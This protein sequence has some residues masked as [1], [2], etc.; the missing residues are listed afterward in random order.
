MRLD[1]YKEFAKFDLFDQ[2]KSSCGD[3]NVELPDQEKIIPTKTFG[4]EKIGHVRTFYFCPRTHR[5]HAPR[6]IAS[7]VVGSDKHL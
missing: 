5:S 6:H 1:C 2:V 4:E 7:L 3:L